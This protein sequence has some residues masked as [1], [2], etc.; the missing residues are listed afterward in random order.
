MEV[1]LF[2]DELKRKLSAQGNKLDNLAFVAYELSSFY[3]MI[4]R[5]ESKSIFPKEIYDELYRMPNVSGYTD[6]TKGLKLKM[7]EGQLW[8]IVNSLGE[9]TKTKRIPLPQWDAFTKEEKDKFKVVFQLGGVKFIAVGIGDKGMHKAFKAL[10]IFILLLF[11]FGVGFIGKILLGQKQ[12]GDVGDYKVMT[13]TLIKGYTSKYD[14]YSRKVKS[15]NDKLRKLSSGN[16]ERKKILLKE[17]RAAEYKVDMLTSVILP[18]LKII[19]NNIND[20]ACRSRIDSYNK[21]ISTF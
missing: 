3:K 18:D 10:K 15:I 1:T 21:K 17:L 13:E 2:I 7:L 4:Q 16:I 8:K 6:L 5:S 9:S 12:N 11:I 19:K 14:F 20:S